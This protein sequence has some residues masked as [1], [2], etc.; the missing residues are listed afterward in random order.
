MFLA[1]LGISSGGTTLCVGQLLLI[2]LFRLLSVVLIGQDNR[3]SSKKKN[4]YQLLY[5]YSLPPDDGLQ[6]RQKH[7][8]VI[9]K[10]Y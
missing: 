1:Y 3:Q 10:I 8:E 4:K 2:I 5:P 6:I 9:D 7:V